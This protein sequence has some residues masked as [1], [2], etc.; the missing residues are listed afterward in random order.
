LAT[1]LG[2]LTATVAFG[3]APA[4]AAAPTP[5][6]TAA[7]SGAIPKGYIGKWKGIRGKATANSRGRVGTAIVT[8]DFGH[9]IDKFEF[10]VAEDGT[11]T[12]AGT[13]TYWFDVSADADL[14][15]TRTAPEAHLEGKSQAVTFKITGKMV[16]GRAELTATPAEEL[17][18]INA[19][20]RT[21]IG[22]WNVFGPGSVLVR[23]TD[24][25]LEIG[26]SRVIEQLGMKLEW[27]ARKASC[28]NPLD[29]ARDL[30]AT[31]YDGWT[32]GSSA[33]NQQVDCVQF[34]LATVEK[35]HGR[36]LPRATRTRILISDVASADVP[37]LVPD[38]D[39][40]IKGVQQALVDIDHGTVVSTADVQPGDFVQYWMQRRDGS[41]MG[42]SAVVA[43]V[44]N[45]AAGTPERIRIYGAQSS[46]GGIALHNDPIRLSGGSRKMYLV[47]YKCESSQNCC[48]Q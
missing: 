12:G 39:S 44:L 1:A 23:K 31:K 11:I 24:K 30:A 17:V 37:V 40:R 45:N 16:A 35:L 20:R 22:A 32:Y 2:W 14:I 19:G 33:A 18:L 21:T 29:V 6:G 3:Q 41:W 7:G 10:E 27:E 43:E 26:A 25:G 9:V 38:D 28:P 36:P 47:R 13:A 5:D 4:S 34:V 42:H 48:Q 46:D 15:V 8:K